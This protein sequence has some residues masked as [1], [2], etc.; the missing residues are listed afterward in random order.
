MDISDL[1][2]TVTAGLVLV[3]GRLQRAQGA[4]PRRRGRVRGR[5][6]RATSTSRSRRASTT[7]SSA[8]RSRRPTPAATQRRLGHRGGQPPADRAQA[9][10]RH[11]RH[12]PVAGRPGA[13]AYL[14]GHLPAHRIALHAGRR[15]GA[16]FGTLDLHSF[17]AN[18]I[19]GP[20]TAEH[21]HV[22]PR[23]ARLRPPEPARGRPARVGGTS[24][25]SSNN[26]TDERALLCPRPGARHA[27]ARRLSDEPAPHAGNH[28]ATEF[29]SRL[30]GVVAPPRPPRPVNIF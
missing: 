19:G 7:P 8:R 10:A 23:A 16:G 22:R 5:A 13:L 21:V 4:Q 28:G 29:L 12:L 6:E 20:L 17:G 1:Q 26:V 15:P 2:A 30:G 9:P 24:R 3:A 14:T 11:R 25:S 18:T 27:C